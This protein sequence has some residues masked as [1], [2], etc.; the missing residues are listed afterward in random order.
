MQEGCKKEKFEVVA[1]LSFFENILEIFKFTHQSPLQTLQP[2]IGMKCA[3]L[4]RIVLQKFISAQTQQL[5]E[6]S[7]NERDEGKIKVLLNDAL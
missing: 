2:N 6:K 5:I 1:Y 3:A 4:Y 7:L